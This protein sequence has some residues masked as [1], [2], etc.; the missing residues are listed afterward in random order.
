MTKS[1][2]LTNGTMYSWPVPLLPHLERKDLYN[3]A[4]NAA[5][6]TFASGS[7][8]SLAIFNCPSS[9]PEKNTPAIGYVANCGS[10]TSSLNKG[11][12]VFFDATG[13]SP[14]RLSLDYVGSGDGTSTTLM[15]AERN[16]PFTNDTLQW[17]V[18]MTTYIGTTTPGFVLP[19]MTATG[20]VINSSANNSQAASA[21]DPIDCPNSFHPSGVIVVF[22][23]SHTQFLRDTI[24]PMVLAQLMTS[25]TETAGDGSYST[26]LPVNES[27]FK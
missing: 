6:G 4:Q 12:G 27:D 14:A 9:A 22:C 19:A 1:Q 8:S 16:G 7:S 5:N 10:G 21:S 15:L 26:L 3:S 24:S 17:S 13:A 25:R 11:Q 18:P 2:S 23:D 20:K